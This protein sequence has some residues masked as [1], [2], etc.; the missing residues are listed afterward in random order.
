MSVENEYYEP[1]SEEKP[2]KRKIHTQVKHIIYGRK[3]PDIYTLTTFVVNLVICLI[4]ILWQVLSLVALYSREYIWQQKDIPVEAIINER[5]EQLGFEHG[6]FL[7]YLSTVYSLS[8]ICWGV[9]FLG[10]IFLYRKQ[11][12]FIYFTIGPLLFYLGMLIF[13]L[14]FQYFIEDTTSFDKV[15]L[16]IAFVSLIFNFYLLKS[17]KT[18]GKINFFGLDSDE[19]LPEHP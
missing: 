3:R 16:L 17:E 9:F 8:L 5:G 6:S 15:A 4:F 1:E 18:N 10:L 2:E 11:K 19:E 12:R 14:N 7:D 13:Y